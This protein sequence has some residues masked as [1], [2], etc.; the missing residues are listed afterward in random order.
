MH[1]RDVVA[2]LVLGIM[3]AAALVTFSR[4]ELFFALIVGTVG[5]VLLVSVAVVVIAHGG[6]PLNLACP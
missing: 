1:T 4:R 2:A 6:T 3:L 5:A